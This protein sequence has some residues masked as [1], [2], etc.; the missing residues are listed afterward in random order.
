MNRPS[1]LLWLE[2]SS[3]GLHDANGEQMKSWSGT[4]GLG[5]DRGLVNIR[6]RLLDKTL[7]IVHFITRVVFVP[8]KTQPCNTKSGLV[9][10]A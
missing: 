1:I 9:T 4:L 2:F 5:D 8:C 3:E 7:Q 10:L 6:N